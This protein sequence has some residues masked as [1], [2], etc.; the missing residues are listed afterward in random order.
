MADTPLTTA[1][2]AVKIIFLKKALFGTE[3]AEFIMCTIS[4]NGYKISPKIFYNT[5]ELFKL[6]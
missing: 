6:C 1:T 2:A 4:E 5:A 3:P